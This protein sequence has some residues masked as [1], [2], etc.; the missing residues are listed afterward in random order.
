MF[1]RAGEGRTAVAHLG[2]CAV[3]AL[4]DVQICCHRNRPRLTSIWGRVIPRQIQLSNP[5][6]RHFH[7]IQ[8]VCSP[9]PL[10]FPSLDCTENHSAKLNIVSLHPA[11]NSCFSN[12]AFWM[13]HFPS[14]CQ[15]E[16][17]GAAPLPTSLSSIRYE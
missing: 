8:W 4:R 10:H 13:W 2:L 17:F 14:W 15:Q 3:F 9:V 5:Q 6:W 7:S 12:H 11:F 1:H 16:E